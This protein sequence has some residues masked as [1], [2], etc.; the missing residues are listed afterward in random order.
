M[1]RAYLNALLTEDPISNLIE[2]VVKQ[3]SNKYDDVL[4]G[5]FERLG[6]TKQ[7]VIKLGQAGVIT[8]TVMNTASKELDEVITY[9]VYGRPV[10]AVSKTSPELWENGSDYKYTYNIVIE[11]Y[12]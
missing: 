11:R 7:E 9:Y 2:S 1:D 5:E 6:F 10:F 8:S 12:M 4:F 3:V